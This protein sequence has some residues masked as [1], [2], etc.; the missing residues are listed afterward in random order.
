MRLGAKQWVLDMHAAF[1]TNRTMSV[2]VGNT[3]SSPTPVTGGAVQGSVL[4][5]LDHNA[6]IEFVDD[7][8]TIETQKYVDDMTTIETI[9][10]ESQEYMDEAYMKPRCTA[11]QRQRKL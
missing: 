1:L 7:G 2:K 6:V 10:S 11:P 4:G 5:V 9:G 3:I 8:F